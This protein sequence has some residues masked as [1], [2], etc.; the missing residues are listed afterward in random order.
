MLIGGFVVEV[1][2][3]MVLFSLLMHRKIS[4]PV[5][6]GAAIFMTAVLLFTPPSDW[7]DTFFLIIELIAIGVILRTAWK[8]PVVQGEAPAL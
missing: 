2:I 8:W 1:P 3:A 7:D 5:N 4:R 6:I